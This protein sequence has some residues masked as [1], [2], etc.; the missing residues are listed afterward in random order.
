MSECAS[1]CPECSAGHYH[2][3]PYAIPYVLDENGVPLPREGV[4]IGRLALFDL[5]AESYW[6]G[7]ITGDK[8]TL[9][10]DNDC[11]CGWKGPYIESNVRR[12]SEITGEEDKISCSG[13]QQAYDE[14]LDFIL[15]ELSE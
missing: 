8:V 11:A 7:F 1:Y 10:F 4:Q 14:F 5:L 15:G 9:H 3:M 6:G 13:S 12:F 2:F